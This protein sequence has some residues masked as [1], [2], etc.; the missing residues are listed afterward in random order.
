MIEDRGAQ[1]S[2][3]S[4]FSRAVPFLAVA[5]ALVTG[6]AWL[7]MP[8][9][10]PPPPP[11][12][13]P[14]QPYPPPPPQRQPPPRSSDCASCADCDCGDCDV[15]DCD[16]SGCDVSGC[17]CDV[18]GCDCSYGPSI[19]ALRSYGLLTLLL[20]LALLDAWRR[21]AI[22]QEALACSAASPRW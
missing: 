6:G 3:L 7:A 20:P 14:Q 19:S 9:M 13:F 11:N 2:G 8:P 17:D 10:Q 16:V 18:S 21:R 4:L 5:F 12:A 15:S 1:R 22:R